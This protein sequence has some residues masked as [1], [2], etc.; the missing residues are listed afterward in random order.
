MK[1]N[2]V[3]VASVLGGLC[4]VALVVVLVW[5]FTKAK[6]PD[7]YPEP[8]TLDPAVPTSAAPQ[9]QSNV[10]GPL[11]K[12]EVLIQQ[13]NNTHT[14]FDST[15]GVLTLT[16]GSPHQKT[17]CGWQINPGSKWNVALT[18]VNYGPSDPKLLTGDDVSL[19]VYAAMKNPPQDIGPSQGRLTVVLSDWQKEAQLSY[20]DA[21]LA[22]VPLSADLLKIGAVNVLSVDFNSGTVRVTINKVVVIP[23]TAIK[24]YTYSADKTYVLLTSFS[25]DA[26]NKHTVKDVFV[27][28]NV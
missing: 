24:T 16:N 13:G 3:V 4:A 22:A 10:R 1:V 5:Y 26:A 20:G 12:P 18:Y 6:R 27:T 14:V 2:K 23:D 9:Q 28:G 17:I 15:T 8:A 21:K 25:G 7:H 11:G 19:H